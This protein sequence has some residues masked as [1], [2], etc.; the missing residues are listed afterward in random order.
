MNDYY[1]IAVV[2]ESMAGKTTWIASHF[3][4]DVGSRS[5]SR[6]LKRSG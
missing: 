6:S 2:G 3:R 1:D 5:R 4:K